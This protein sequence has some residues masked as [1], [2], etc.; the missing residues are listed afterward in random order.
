MRNEGNFLIA[1]RL[2][3]ERLC[4]IISAL[5]SERTGARVT[6]T[7]REEQNAEYHHDYQR[8][9]RGTAEGIL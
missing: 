1:G 5:E 3:V 4:K 7:A 6:I 2:D 9:K 8:P